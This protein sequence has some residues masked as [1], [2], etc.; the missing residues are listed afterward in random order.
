MN[1]P[2]YDLVRS[3]AEERVFRLAENFYEN[4][5][6]FIEAHGDPE[7]DELTDFDAAAFQLMEFCC[8]IVAPEWTW[9]IGIEGS[10]LSVVVVDF[11]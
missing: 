6:V 8:K 5:E 2:F 7:I 1:E 4:R 10:D 3:Q 9:R 11:Q